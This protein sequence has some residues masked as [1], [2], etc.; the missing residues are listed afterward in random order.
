ME[1]LGEIA[2]L[3]GQLKHYQVLA[4]QTRLQIEDRTKQCHAAMESRGQTRLT[5]GELNAEIRQIKRPTRLSNEDKL[6]K[7]QAFLQNNGVNASTALIQGL[8]N[9]TRG[10]LEEIASLRLRRQ[11]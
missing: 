8:R 5:N 4:R 6:S 2:Q 9:C 1:F 7:T 11:A 10:E 3:Q